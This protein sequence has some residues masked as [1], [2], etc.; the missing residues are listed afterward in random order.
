MAAPVIVRDADVDDDGTNTTGTVHN[1]SW[2]SAIYNRIDA[3]AAALFGV[4]GGGTGVSTLAA[5]GVVLGNGTSAVA[6]TGAGTAGQVL[7]SNG[8][9]AD[10]TF[11]AGVDPAVC[12]GRLTLTT[13]VPVTTA[14]VTGAT[15]VFFTPYRGNTI[16]LYDGAAA[17]TVLTFTEK[18][19]ALG[20]LTNDLPYDVFAFNNSGVVAL[21]LL[22]WSTKTARATALVLQ[23]GVLVKTGATTRRYLGT[24]KTTSTTTTEDSYAKRDLYNHYQQVT[25]ALKVVESTDTWTY[26]TATIRQARASTANQLEVM[27][28]VA[29]HAIHVALH[30]VVTT[31]TPGD[32]LYSFIGE[33]STTTA[34]TNAIQGRHD[35]PTVGFLSNEAFLNVVPA[36]GLRQFM[37]LERGPGGASTVTWY[38][39]NGGTLVQSGIAGHIR[40]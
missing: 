38:G 7:M 22:A 20:T 32:D 1:N 33:D 35:A 3:L 23:D 39:D 11:Q 29:E 16:G 36:V 10:P 27:V 24:F 15:N 34:S 21:E 12:N 6:V 14:D 8:A 4:A 9:S 28:G 25:R 18:T 13:A 19:L 26:G 2:K 40:M 5:H 37:W 30:A 17:W 31:N